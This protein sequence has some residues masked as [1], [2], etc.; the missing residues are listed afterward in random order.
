MSSRSKFCLALACLF[1]VTGIA[2]SFTLAQTRQPSLGGKPHEKMVALAP[3]A[4]ADPHAKKRVIAGQPIPINCFLIDGT[5]APTSVQ[6]AHSGAN[7]SFKCRIQIPRGSVNQQYDVYLEPD[8]SVTSNGITT[9]SGNTHTINFGPSGLGTYQQDII[10]QVAYASGMDPVQVT[11]VPLGDNPYNSLYSIGC[12]VPVADGNLV[13]RSIV[14]ALYDHAI[15]VENKTRFVF[16]CT[17]VRPHKELSRGAWMLGGNDQL[18]PSLDGSNFA[19]WPIEA[20]FD[21]NGVFPFYIV[22]DQPLL[23]RNFRFFLRQD[24][25]DKSIQLRLQQQ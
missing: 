6:Q 1:L 18:T 25:K 15:Q 17:L 14:H 12:F 5:T 7:V 16:K 23:S 24:E 4:P 11:V 8:G 10:V 13:T 21:E 22:S 20:K 19:T 3:L 9:T 2:A